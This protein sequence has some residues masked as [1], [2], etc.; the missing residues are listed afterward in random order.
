M[1]EVGGL[2]RMMVRGWGRERMRVRTVVVR[3]EGPG[4]C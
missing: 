3:G 4:V 1:G 2:E